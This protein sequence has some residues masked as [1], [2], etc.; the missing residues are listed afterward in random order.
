MHLAPQNSQ[1]QIPTSVFCFLKI[2]KYLFEAQLDQRNCPTIFVNMKFIVKDPN[3]KNLL[4]FVHQGASS[5]QNSLKV[6]VTVEGSYLDAV[7]FSAS[8]TY[9]KVEQES[10][11][12]RTVFVDSYALCLQYRA[13]FTSRLKVSVLKFIQSWEMMLFLICSA[14]LSLCRAK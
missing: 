11:S 13:Y 4:Y 6:E 8:T 14:G 3:T 5:Y 9:K 1:L 12:Q 10:N 2:S 7:S